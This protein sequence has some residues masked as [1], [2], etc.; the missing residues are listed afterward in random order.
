MI[1]PISI[2]LIL[3]STPSFAAD[4]AQL[5]ELFV[6]NFKSK[7]ES[8]KSVQNIENLVRDAIEQGIDLMGAELVEIRNEARETYGLI[9][10]FQAR[11]LSPS[12]GDRGMSPSYSRTPLNWSFHHFLLADGMVFDFDFRN[13]PTILTID[14][15]INEMFIPKSRQDD[16]IYRKKKMADYLLQFYSLHP[17]QTKQSDL[18]LNNRI[19][20]QSHKYRLSEKLQEWFSPEKEYA[21]KC[22]KHYLSVLE[23]S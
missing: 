5:R 22:I 1:K 18:T 11:E 19:F 23:E 10:V 14:S 21:R 9:S 12:S 4:L 2:L 6:K 20:F 13:D 16:P 7:Y 17:K 3:F 8:R 15:Y